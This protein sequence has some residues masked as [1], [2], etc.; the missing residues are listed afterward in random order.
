MIR[1]CQI[2]IRYV[3]SEGHT[4]PEKQCTGC[5]QVKKLDEFPL[6]SS[7]LDGHR[8]MCFVCVD[9]GK[10]RDNE[11]KRQSQSQ[12]RQ[13][14]EMLRAQRATRNMLFKA[15]GYKWHK[16]MVPV[17][18][19]DDVDFKET[20]V[21]RDPTGIQIDIEDAIQEIAELNRHHP[22]HAS[23][24]WAQD[25]L[26][27]SNV[28]ILDTETTG[29]SNDAEVIDIAIVDCA[30]NVKLNTLIQ[31]QAS[32]PAEAKAVHHINE[33]M[34]RS[35]P[36][37]EQIWPKLERLLSTHEIIIYN[38][39]YDIRLL[40]QTAKRYKLDLPEMKVHC[41]MKHYSSYVGITSSHVEGYRNLKLAAACIHFRIEQT[42]AHRALVDSQASLHVLRGLAAHAV[43]L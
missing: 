26:A 11:Q 28:L 33:L 15:Y 37:F 24:Q 8:H 25:I 3:E 2:C 10:K 9:A 13:Q 4:H 22:S 23:T 17:E 43:L 42:E 6:H 34:L 40:K 35:A 36:T 39:E 31:C 14:Q 19:E 27:R 5:Q 12:M 20:W 29:F 30:G 41:L 38:A 7:S 32:I 1:Y 21:L 16:E 18:Y